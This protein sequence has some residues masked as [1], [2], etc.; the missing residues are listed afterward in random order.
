MPLKNNILFLLVGFIIGVVLMQQCNRKTPSILHG[1]KELIK[2][3]TIF[4]TKFEVYEPINL[5]PTLTIPTAQIKP[6]F[7]TLEQCQTKYDTIFLQHNDTNYYCIDTGSVNAELWITQN[8]LFKSRFTIET[9]ETEI[10]NTIIKRRFQVLYGG[11]LNYPFGAH[12]SAGFKTK[13]ELSVMYHY[14]TDNSH[15]IG[16]LMPLRFR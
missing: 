15:R 14:G 13:K 9:N 8:R 12:L 2:T 11:G 7:A 16:V 6:T 10:T 5:K 3:D 4:R 1:Q